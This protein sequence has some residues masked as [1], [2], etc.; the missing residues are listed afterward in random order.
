MSTAVTI[1]PMRRRHLPA[2]LAIETQVYPKPWSSSL[3]GTAED[4]RSP[5]PS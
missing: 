5:L 2:V 3:F 4:P 1:T